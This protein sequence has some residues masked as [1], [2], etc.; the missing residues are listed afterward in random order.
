MYRIKCYLSLVLGAL[1]PDTKIRKMLNCMRWKDYSFPQSLTLAH[2][3][4]FHSSFL[5]VIIRFI[6]FL[7]WWLGLILDLKLMLFLMSHSGS[8]DLD[9]LGSKSKAWFCKLLSHC[10]PWHELRSYDYSLW[11]GGTHLYPGKQKLDCFNVVLSKF[12]RHVM[13]LGVIGC[14]H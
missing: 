2:H 14:G 4:P 12:F 3:C 5:I 1:L 8:G 7:G 6:I 10:F 9:H 11:C 13:G